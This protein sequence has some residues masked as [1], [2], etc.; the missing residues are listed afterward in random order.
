M[1]VYPSTSPFAQVG[2][3]A[4]GYGR[5]VPA[6][7]YPR[8]YAAAQNPYPPATAGRN[9]NTQNNSYNTA[10]NNPHVYQALLNNHA[11]TA[12][13]LCGACKTYFLDRF[14]VIWQ[15]AVPVAT[16]AVRMAARFFL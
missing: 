2:Y 11:H 1:M 16:D 9:D 13:Q 10:F 8:Y 7:S 15:E 5:P 12:N 3:N 14:P 4:Y 6:P